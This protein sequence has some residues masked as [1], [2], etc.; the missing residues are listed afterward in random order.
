[1]SKRYLFDFFTPHHP[2]KN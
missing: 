1:M 2:Y